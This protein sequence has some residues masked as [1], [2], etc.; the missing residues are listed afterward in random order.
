MSSEQ[1]EPHLVRR[2]LTGDKTSFGRLYE[3]YLDEIYHFVYYQVQ[4]HHE[5]EDLTETVFL[6][7][8]QAL[9]KNPPREVPFRLWLYRIARN[10]V[11][12]YYRTRKNYADLETASYVPDGVEGPEAAAVRRERD[13]GLKDKIQQLNEVYQEILTY[14]FVVGL[15]HAETAVV[16]SRSE[17]A[18]RAL[19][20]RA[21]VALRNLIA[22]E[23][24]TQYMDDH[25]AIQQPV[26]GT[27]LG[28]RLAS[29]EG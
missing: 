28:S 27:P 13:A 8:W 14:R 1:L 21:I 24:A 6:K 11:V 3:V 25:T 23:E 20:Y 29:E 16:M 22:M 17:Q 15:S 2:A 4:S 26:F 18:V 7:A 10:S 9:R 5:A 12:D 19:Q